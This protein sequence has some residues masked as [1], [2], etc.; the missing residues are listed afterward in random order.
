MSDA[1]A[2]GS[3]GLGLGGV[4][5]VA[6]RGMAGSR[7]A[8]WEC[9]HGRLPGDRTPACGCWVENAPRLARPLTGE[10]TRRM[11]VATV[12]GVI[13]HY[14]RTLTRTEWRRE[15]LQP[16]T[17]TVE[18]LCGSWAEAVAAAEALLVSA[19]RAA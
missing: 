16:S 8:V 13:A 7:D 15:G 1:R 12:A 14:E 5:P 17:A 3:F 2:G 19:R 18:R 10:W 9:R 6:C 11:A 4:D